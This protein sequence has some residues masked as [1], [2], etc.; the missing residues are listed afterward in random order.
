MQANN[1]TVTI[2]DATAGYAVVARDNLSGWKIVDQGFTTDRSYAAIRA[3]GIEGA[4]V[5]PAVQERQELVGSRRTPQTRLV[6]LVDWQA[7]HLSVRT[8]EPWWA[9]RVV[10]GAQRMASRL[11]DPETE[12]D[13]QRI[14]F[15]RGETIIE[16][17]LRE[18]GVDV[19]MPAFWREVRAH[20]G[21]KIRARRLPLLVGY[22]FIRHDPGRGFDPIREIDGVIDVVKVQRSP[23]AVSEDDIRFIMV[24]MFRQEQAYRWAKAQK[25]EEARFKRRQTLNAELGR[26]LPRGR[27]RTVSLRVYADAC[28]TSMDEVARKRVLGIMSAID[29]LE[30]DNSLDQFREA[31]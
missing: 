25:I 22:A 13:R 6:V 29:G 19:Y 2:L 20:R 15:R 26:H 12:E 11:P 18:A 10:P 9:V 27:G 14:E 23:V 3:A 31:V 4:Q 7:L 28:I 30:K 21:G 24:E 17:N 5:L 8:D 16:R 1:E